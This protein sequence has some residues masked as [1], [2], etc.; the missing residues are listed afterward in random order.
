MKWASLSL[1]SSCG[2]SS[3]TRRKHVVASWGKIGLV[4]IRVSM[5]AIIII[6]ILLK[7]F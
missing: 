6:N 4:L 3:P 2:G 1:P 7:L 5:V